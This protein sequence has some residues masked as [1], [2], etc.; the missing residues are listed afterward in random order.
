MQHRTP[1]RERFTVGVLVRVLSRSELERF[2]IEWKWHHPLQKEQL[3]FADAV[4]KVRD[5]S[6]YHGG[7]VLYSLDGVLGIWH[8]ECLAQASLEVTQ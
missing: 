8:E 4:A 6:F 1:Y 7:D 2:S 5:V 3:S